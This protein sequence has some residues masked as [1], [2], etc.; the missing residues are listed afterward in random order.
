[1]VVDNF[2]HFTAAEK[3]NV[4]YASYKRV[5]RDVIMDDP[6]TGAYLCALL[7]E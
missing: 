4:P 3:V 2:D 7:E 5:R 1:M 6:D